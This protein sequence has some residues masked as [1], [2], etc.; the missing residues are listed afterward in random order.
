MPPMNLALMMLGTDCCMSLRKSFPF[1]E[2]LSAN[3]V[4]STSKVDSISVS[5]MLAGFSHCWSNIFVEDKKDISTFFVSLQ[6]WEVC[7]D[8]VFQVG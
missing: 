8:P 1:C 4:C 7:K 3:N 2:D 6:V 5:I